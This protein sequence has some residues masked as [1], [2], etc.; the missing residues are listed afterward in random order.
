MIKKQNILLVLDETE[1]SIMLEAFDNYTYHWFPTYIF[2]KK[3]EKYHEQNIIFLDK[4][5]TTSG[6]FRLNVTEDNIYHLCEALRWN[7]RFVF[8]EKERD[9]DDGR[10]DLYTELSY[11]LENRNKNIYLFSDFD[12]K[13]YNLNTQI[14]PFKKFDFN[15]KRILL[16][17]FDKEGMQFVRE[18]YRQPDEID[19][20]YLKRA[21]EAVLKGD[22]DSLN[23]VKYNNKF[24]DFKYKAVLFS[25][26]NKYKLSTEFSYH[27]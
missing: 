23:N 6:G 12:P 27:P 25:D 21:D 5:K 11:I 16:I 1:R 26:L 20:S 17:R 9:N 14:K 18:F 19:E 7:S 22:E 10:M 13:Q 4:L 3:H 15:Q 8:T 2:N 24:L